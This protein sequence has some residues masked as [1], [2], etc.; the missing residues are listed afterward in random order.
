MQVAMAALSLP[1]LRLIYFCNYVTPPELLI[2]YGANLPRVGGG[3]ETTRNAERKL[4][5][6]VRDPET[7]TI[8]H[9]HF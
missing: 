7:S 1:Y 2:T 8:K 6:R 3:V 9:R 5:Y 4:F